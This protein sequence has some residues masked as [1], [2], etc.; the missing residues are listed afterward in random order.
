MELTEFLVAWRPLLATILGV[1]GLLFLILARQVNAFA[2]LL[3]AALATGLAAGLAPGAV[4]ESIQNGFAGVLG[5]IAVIVGLGA[6]LGTYLEASG[7]AAALARS[8]VGN[9]PPGPAGIAMGFVGLVIAIPVFFDVGLILLFPLVRA[10]AAKAGKA[11]MYFGLPLLAGLATAHAFI[12]PTPGPVAV[13]E[14]LGAEIGLVIVCGLIA[15]IPAMLIA[16]PYYARFADNRG[17][18]PD[19]LESAEPSEDTAAENG[20]AARA[21][22]AIAVPI[23]LIVMAAIAAQVGWDSEF[24]G[25]VGHPFVAL[26]VGCG[27][28]A[29]ALRPADD[30]GRA[31]LKDGLTRAL[32]P[33]AVILLVTG[34]GGAFKQVLVDTGAGK[35]MAEGFLAFGM[36]PIIAGFLLAALVRVAQGSA[37]VAMLTAAGLSAPLAVAAGLEGWDLAR[38]VI[39]IAAGASIISHVN[40]SG[41]WLVSRY[42]G[43]TAGETL[44]TWTIASTLVGIVGFVAVLLLGLV[45]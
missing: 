42:F 41:F 1:V 43:L 6:L 4:L 25:F 27:L 16:G 10:L 23:A 7:G 24:I 21:S 2:A 34:A 31:R 11:A 35:M 9:R 36:G 14:I 39:A 13:A 28:A 32:E 37:T 15:G 12:P 3:V 29:W 26:L 22:A 38:M 8:I 20:L 45:L 19:R 18:L 30:A 17:W 44:K 33:T 40:D 5:F